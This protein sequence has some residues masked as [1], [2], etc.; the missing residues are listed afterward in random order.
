[1]TIDNINGIPINTITN[2]YGIPTTTINNIL[3]I[4]WPSGGSGGGD[5]YS[6]TIGQ[7]CR[8][9]DD[10]SAYLTRTPSAGNRKTW[11]YSC[12]F[13][14]GNIG[15]NML[16][17]TGGAN[18]DAIYITTDG[19]VVHINN[20]NVLYTSNLYRDVS[21]WY[22]MVVIWDTTPANPGSD[23]VQLWINGSIPSFQVTN[24][25]SQNAESEINSAVANNIGNWNGSLYWDG[26]MAE[27]H[28]LDGIKGAPTDF[29]EFQNGVWVP[30]E[31]TGSYGTNGFHLDFADSAD[32]GNDVSGNGNDFTATNLV[33]TDQVTDTPTNNWC[34]LNA[35]TPSA[36]SKNIVKSDGNLTVTDASNEDASILSTFAYDT[37]DTDGIY[38]EAKV[39]TQGPNHYIGVANDTLSI[40][41]NITGHSDAWVLGV[42]TYQTGYVYNGGSGSNIGSISIND[43]IMVA[44][45]GNKIWWGING[46]WSG[47]PSAGTGALYS[48]L[49]GFITSVWSNGGS[50]SPKA[51]FNF[52]QDSTNVS[53]GN[54]DEN[55]Y[56]NFEYTPPTG[57]LAL[58]SA[59][60]SD[61]AWMT[62]A[63][64]DSPSDAFDA[65]TREGTGAEAS[66]SDL[67]FSPDIVLIKDR[68]TAYSWHMIDSERGA[69]KRLKPDDNSA[70]GT[71]VQG[72]KSFDVNGYTLGTANEYNTN[73]D[74]YVDYSW[75]K[76][77]TYGIDIVEY[78][79]NATNRAINHSLGATPSVMIV[80]N[81]SQP[82]SW[83]VYHA[84]IADDAETD[85]LVLEDTSAAGDLTEIWNDT[86]PTSTQF[87]VG[88]NA[89][90]NGN[91]ENLVAYLFAE[92]VGF[93]KFGYYT[94]NG[95]AD[96]PF[97]YCGFRPKMLIIKN[98]GAVA[99]WQVHDLARNINNPTQGGLW[100][101]L[102]SSESQD[103]SYNIDIISNG[104]KIRTSAAP[105]NTAG[106]RYIFMA[107]AEFPFKYSNAR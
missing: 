52:G 7:S 98:T 82:R 87:T 12:W 23:D 47:D 24:Y 86:A 61:P 76:S 26:Y 27:V 64:S 70:E 97:V 49:A 101:N 3:G 62:D 78:T 15:V 33:A 93:S 28:F 106:I 71:D 95:N 73:G 34:V 21:S 60:L 58:C 20:T 6:K 79:G 32:L 91:G 55:G 44:V 29:G 72:L 30:K 25:P 103:P 45:K 54:A 102:S 56:G 104:F 68:D 22:H 19:F 69:T 50:G 38:F 63:T 8:F 2:V 31:F 40:T 80:K 13:K 100:P 67:D 89:A 65:I 1:M 59:N 46:S 74:N 41:N 77:A 48:N 105:R 92:V 94:G 57:F 90:V 16:L 35:L 53:S 75:L 66:I 96:G 4:P 9:N 51:S 42:G 17:G 18:E 107:F 99:D 39:L 88:T 11:T 5:F 84:G 14:R 36:M 10:D 83:L 81:L 37:N 43:I 85:Y